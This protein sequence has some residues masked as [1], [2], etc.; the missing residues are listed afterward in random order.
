VT[1]RVTFGGTFAGL[2]APAS[3]ALLR[4]LAG[5]GATAPALL[6]PTTLTVGTSGTFSGSG[7][8]TSGQA[9]GVVSGQTY[10]E[11]ADAEFPSGELPGQ[12]SVAPAVPAIPTGSTGLL[13]IALLGMGIAIGGQRYAKQS[14][15]RVQGAAT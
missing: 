5:P 3:T 6:P 9:A 2:S 8:L 14:V 15:K 1:L 12:L 4:G 10:C 13:I 11:I 7:T